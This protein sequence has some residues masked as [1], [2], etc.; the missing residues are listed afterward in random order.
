MSKMV[1]VERTTHGQCVAH[2]MGAILYFIR[3]LFII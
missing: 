2:T 3:K 1:P